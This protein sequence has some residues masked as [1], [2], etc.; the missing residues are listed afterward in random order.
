MQDAVLD[1]RRER[2][3]TRPVRE[4][5]DGHD[6]DVP[7]EHERRFAR[8]GCRADHA[9]PL[10]PGRLGAREVGVGAQV[11]EVEGPQVD[12]EPGLLEP[13]GHGVLQLALGVGAG[14]AG[15]AHQLD[16]GVDQLALVEGVEHAALGGGGR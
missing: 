5:A 7:L 3:R 4:V 13:A 14:D 2:L 12:L 6:V 9:V 1:A 11:V 16:E 8:S 10:D 15:D